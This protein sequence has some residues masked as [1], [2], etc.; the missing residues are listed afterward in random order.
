MSC[1]FAKESISSYLD[2][3]LT[4][5][6]RDRVSQHLSVC[7]ECA[8]LRRQ[9]AQLRESL[10]AIPPAHLP[11]K[12]AID[13]RILASRELLR[14]H[15]TGSFGAALEFWW[16]RTRLMMD[17]LMRPLALPAA[18]G[19]TSALF[20]VG[21][22]VQSLGFL[23]TPG[24]DRPSALF[25][26]ASVDN[27]ADFGAHSKSADDTLIEVKVDGQGRMVDYYVPQ[28]QMTSEIGNLLLFTTFTPATKFLQ[29]TSGKIVIR[30]SRIVVKG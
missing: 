21:M 18:G 19:V 6:E 24:A 15:H 10:R 17:N 3:R 20:I 22:L 25:T 11:R 8:T 23:H 13:L 26:E 14:S 27:V 2:G 30:L 16:A 1:N 4:G 5:L 12:L 9:T 7:R 28:G 29:P